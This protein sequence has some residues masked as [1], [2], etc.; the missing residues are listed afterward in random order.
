[1]DSLRHKHIQEH[2]KHL[3][4]EGSSGSG[5]GKQHDMPYSPEILGLAPVA[6]PYT[7]DQEAGPDKPA[8][9]PVTQQDWSQDPAIA[10][11]PTDASQPRAEPGC[12]TS[13]PGAD[14]SSHPAQAQQSGSGV[15]D[16][17]AMPASSHA[18]NKHLPGL[19]AAVPEAD[20]QQQAPGQE[21][22]AMS[23]GSGSGTTISQAVPPLADAE[24][25]PPA[26]VTSQAHQTHGLERQ[27]QDNPA[28][29]EQGAAADERGQN[30]VVTWQPVAHFLVHSITEVA[31]MKLLPQFLQH[32]AQVQTSSSRFGCCT[33][34]CFAA[35]KELSDLAVTSQLTCCV[36]E[37]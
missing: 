8:S 20:R 21:A 5:Q 33:L 25:P 22:D 7:Q 11:N 31:C 3:L 19:S 35:Q 18:A 12:A 28:S 36:P 9:P 37:G 2:S 34:L 24:S 10:V 16:E 15:A 23:G 6:Q 1:M 26:E 14:H 13:L 32:M 27:Q 29:T 30:V 17:G 4:E